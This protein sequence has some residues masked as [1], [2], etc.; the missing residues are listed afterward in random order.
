MDSYLDND[1]SQVAVPKR[2]VRDVRRFIQDFSETNMLI[3]GEEM[4]DEQIARFIVDVVDEWNASPPIMQQYFVDPANVGL[5]PNLRG[6]RVMIVNATAARALKTI[7]LRLARNDMPYTAGNVTVQSDAV[8]RNLQ[9]LVQDLEIQY[10][11]SRL[12]YKVAQNISGVWGVA[13]SDFLNATYQTGRD[14]FIVVSL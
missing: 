14:G 12:D 10:K 11:Q 5:N 3:D 9:A 6:V 8:W 4:T 7:I 1:G 13:H 2:L